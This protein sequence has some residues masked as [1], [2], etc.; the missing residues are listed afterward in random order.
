MSREAR[1]WAWDQARARSISEPIDLLILQNLADVADEDG[2]NSHPSRRRLS[3]ECL[4]SE[5]T[6]TRR[7]SAL[8]DRGIIEVTTP[9]TRT[10]PTTYRLVGVREHAE[11]V[12]GISSGRIGRQSVAP[13]PPLERRNVTPNASSTDGSGDIGE[14]LGRHWGD[15]PLRE[16]S[17]EVEVEVEVKDARRS[18]DASDPEHPEYGFDRWWNRYPARNGKRGS[19]AKALALWKKLTY[20]EKQEAWRQVNEYVRIVSFGRPPMDADRWLRLGNEVKWDPREGWSSADASQS[21]R[22]GIGAAP[23]PSRK[24][25][26]EMTEDELAAIWPTLSEGE[27][28][29]AEGARRQAEIARRRAAGQ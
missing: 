22:P 8:V 21:I 6:I 15:T 25:W 26:A 3:E 14:T 1:D 20:A 19:K 18:L 9:A 10:R 17:D 11:A 23:L 28:T 7:L 13:N 29:E 4:A 5:R 27:R 24:P 2:E 16:T 12:R